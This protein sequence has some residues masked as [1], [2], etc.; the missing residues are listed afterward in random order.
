MACIVKDL[1]KLC[2]IADTLPN[3]DD[4]VA[5]N[6]ITVE[7]IVKVPPQKLD[8]EQLLSV[9]VEV[10]IEKISHMY[11]VTPGNFEGFV[12]P[13]DRQD[14]QPFS[15]SGSKLAIE[16]VLKQ[17]IQYVA[18][19]PEQSVHAIHTEKNFSAFIALPSNSFTTRAGLFP[20]GITTWIDAIEQGFVTVTP[21]VLDIFVRQINRRCIFKNITI[22][23][24]VN[25][26]QF[27]TTIPKFEPCCTPAPCCSSCGMDSDSF[28]CNFKDMIQISGI[29]KEVPGFDG[30]VPFQQFEI[31]ENLTIPDAKPNIESITNVSLEVDGLC[32]SLVNTPSGTGPD[33][34][35]LTG[36]KLFVKGILKQ[37]VEYI[38]DLPDQPIHAAHFNVPFCTYI[39]LP[40]NYDPNS[41]V[42]LE[43][44]IENG[45]VSQCGPRSLFKNITLAIVA[46]VNAPT[47]I[48]DNC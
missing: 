11:A 45:F 39:V 34:K 32:S 17:K 37:K 48:D 14:Q 46:I 1:I 13:F 8:I 3:E 38:A 43:A 20:P 25:L 44:V 9:S 22:L 28:D 2:G 6:Q 4:I 7:E 30:E 31:E 5:L 10:C 15:N 27:N 29:A 47:E 35:I 18:D 41:A 23:L 42:Q 19:E 33:G 24:N 40:E 16:G 12:V 21:F 36:T 26:N